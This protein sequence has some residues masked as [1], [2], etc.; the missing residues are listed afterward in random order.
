MQ[1]SELFA[2]F[3]LT[4]CHP[5]LP[6]V[7]NYGLPS[8]RPNFCLPTCLPANLSAC[9]PACLPISLPYAVLNQDKKL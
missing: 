4:S 6:V 7:S 9:Q 5:G 1:A 8:C 2:S 3:W